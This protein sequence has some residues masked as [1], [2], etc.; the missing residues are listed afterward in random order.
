[1]ASTQSAA[2]VVFFV[3]IGNAYAMAPRRRGGE[4]T[5]D[6]APPVQRARTLSP[7][8]MV[9]MAGEPP[10]AEAE[11]NVDAP[12]ATGVGDAPFAV[13]DGGALECA[14]APDATTADATVEGASAPAA[15]HHQVL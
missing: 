11:A 9:P 12:P 4:P 14:S 15:T 6:H 2:I 7:V 8:R 13:E 10:L 5:T 3:L 1:M